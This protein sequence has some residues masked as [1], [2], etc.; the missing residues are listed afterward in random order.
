MSDP[1]LSLFDQLAEKER[2]KLEATF[3]ERHATI[4]ACGDVMRGAIATVRAREWH[5]H[6]VLWNAALFLN[7]VSYDLS[8]GIQNFAY[9]RDEWKR[10]YIARTLALLLFEI[11][12]DLSSVF[13]KRFRE[14]AK[15]LGVPSHQIDSVSSE[16]KRISAFWNQNRTLFKEIRTMAGAHRDHDAIALHETIDAIDLFDLLGLGLQLGVL[17]NSL[18]AAT[19][20]ILRFTAGIEPKE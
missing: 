18:G 3:S 9:E 19:Q 17:T 7:T 8:I 5:T 16:T 2:K 1:T 15:V 10:R 14:A 11:G 13:G 12:E 6:E 20:P 4:A